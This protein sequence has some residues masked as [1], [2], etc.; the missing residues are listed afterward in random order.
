MLGIDKLAMSRALSPP[1][2]RHGGAAGGGLLGALLGGSVGG[3]LGSAV[4][5]FAVDAVRQQ[6]GPT[7]MALQTMPQSALDAL[8]PAIGNVNHTAA[9]SLRNLLRS[10]PRAFALR[11]AGAGALALG[12]A[13]L[14]GGGLI[15]FF[16]NRSRRGAWDK[17]LLGRLSRLLGTNL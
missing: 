12:G 15:D 2:N 5:P 16:R 8:Q 13:G 4:H 14:L 7:S 10:T 11:G 9:T 1:E 3:A 6:I 17:S